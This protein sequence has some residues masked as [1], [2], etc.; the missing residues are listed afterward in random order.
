MVSYSSNMPVQHVIKG[1]AK[2]AKMYDVHRR[3]KGSA[4]FA[5]RDDLPGETVDANTLLTAIASTVALP[6]SEFTDELSLQYPH[7]NKDTKAERWKV[8]YIITPSGEIHRLTMTFEKMFGSSPLLF[9]DGVLIADW[10]EKIMFKTAKG[11]E[12]VTCKRNPQTAQLGWVGTDI[13]FVVDGVELILRVNNVD[14]CCPAPL[15]M[16]AGKFPCSSGRCDTR[17]VTHFRVSDR[18]V[19]DLPR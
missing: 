14:G 12:G 17:S 19:N 10:A 15:L 3:K 18:Y 4:G 8:W 13:F 5:R 16:L 7:E 9:L 6:A 2:A 1:I 11:V